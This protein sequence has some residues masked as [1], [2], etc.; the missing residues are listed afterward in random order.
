MMETNFKSGFVTLVGR[1]N[2]GKST[3]LNDLIGEKVSIVSDK[4]QT[5][6][7]RIHGIYTDEEAQIIFVDTPGVHKPRHELGDTMVTTSLQTLRDVDV[8]LFII[9]A[10]E[11]YGPGDEFIIEKLKEID[12]PVFL[13]INK[14][15]LVHPDE[16][17]PLITEYNDKFSFAET[18]PVSALNG[19]NVETLRKVITDYLPEGP[20]YYSKEDKTDRSLQFHISEIIREKVLYYT[21]EEIPHSVHV[22]I[23]HMEESRGT[24]HI[25]ATI[26]TERPSQKGILIGKRG[27]MLKQI[28]TSARKELETYLQTKVNLQLW[29]K[30]VKD[31]R[32]RRNLLEQYGFEIL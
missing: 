14:I 26:I 1:P 17:L 28:G 21:E 16:L 32:N 31:W 4:I 9:D 23:E 11:G 10:K 20:Q 22:L 2:V 24:T 8:V 5:T 27:N 12:L 15:D 19:N 7:N 13:V 18:V 29:V 25:H 30:I 3:L 6:R